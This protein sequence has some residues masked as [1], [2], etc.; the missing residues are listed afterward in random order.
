M[1]SAKKPQSWPR[2]MDTAKAIEASRSHNSQGRTGR[3][4]PAG[5]R[6]ESQL[7]PL[8]RSTGLSPAPLVSSH[9]L[10]FVKPREDKGEGLRKHTWRSALTEQ[11]RVTER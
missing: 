6:R 7:V 5:T 10:S 9:C 8:E 11:S 3:D 4:L 1:N 2:L